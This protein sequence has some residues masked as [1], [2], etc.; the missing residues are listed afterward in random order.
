MSA[1]GAS[2]DIYDEEKIARLLHVQR[3]HGIDFDKDINWN[4]SI[5]LNKSL[6]PLDHK[7]ILFPDASAEERLVI[8]QLMGLIVAATISELENVAIR[9]KGPTWENILRKYPVNPEIREMGELFYED[10]AK[11]SAAFKRYIDLFAEKVNVDPKDL[12]EF[13]PSSTHSLAGKI[14]ELNSLGGGMAIWWLIAAVEEEALLIFDHMRKIKT[15]VDPLYYEIHK[16]HYEEEIRHK[17]YASIMLKINS[18]FA[19]APQSIIFRKIDFILAEILNITWT[20]N[21]L[22]KVKNLKK[23]ENHHEF[24][25]TLSVLFD[26][27][28]SRNSLEVVHT[29]FTTAPYIKNMLN[30]SEH[31]HIRV[32]LERFGAQ[33][34]P[35]RMAGEF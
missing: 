13:L 14:Y 30:L 16:C 26:V 10:E 31:K 23:L 32:M 21:Q 8:S 4:Q 22:Y 2:I 12:K 18:E 24:F 15:H 28:E 34:I 19:K 20:F 25:K 17:S 6:L 27:L 33:K 3:V 5:D 11:H 29:L 1:V 35:F 7:A 9:L